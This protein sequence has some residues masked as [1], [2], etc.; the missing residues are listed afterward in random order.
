MAVMIGRIITTR[1][2]TAGAIPGPWGSVEKKGSQPSRL[3]SPVRPGL[4]KGSITK[5]AHRPSTT[6]GLAASSSTIT[7]STWRIWSGMMFSVMNT[8][9]PTPRGTAISSAS[10]EVI[11]VP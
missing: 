11:R 8:A 3:W 10:R 4:R 5:I 1:I 2:R 6:E 7:P 9:V